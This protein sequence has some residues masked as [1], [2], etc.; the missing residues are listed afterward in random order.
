MVFSRLEILAWPSF[1]ALPIVC[2]LIRL[3]PGGIGKEY[4]FSV[5]LNVHVYYTKIVQS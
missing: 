3:L 5:F 2:I 1:M 4:E